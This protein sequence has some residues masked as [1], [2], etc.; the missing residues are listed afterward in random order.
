MAAECLLCGAT[1][2][3]DS[4]FAGLQTVADV[5]NI[6]M[7]KFIQARLGAVSVGIQADADTHYGGR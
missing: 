2:L 7:G 1:A 3:L 5:L 4:S 6:Q